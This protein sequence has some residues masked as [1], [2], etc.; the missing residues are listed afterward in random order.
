MKNG[1]AGVRG[2]F[3]YIWI[4]LFVWRSL[5]VGNIHK[6]DIEAKIGVWWNRTEIL[7]AV[8]YAVRQYDFGGITAA[9][10]G[11]CHR[12]ALYGIVETGTEYS[13]SRRRAE[14]T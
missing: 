6:T 12:P 4:L 13:R 11:E 3:S 7:G 1:H 14:L 2:R 9:H 5:I 8:R 10:V